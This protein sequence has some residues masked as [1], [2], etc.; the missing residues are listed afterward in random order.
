MQIKTLRKHNVNCAEC[1]EG[2]NR[3]DLYALADKKKMH[4]YCAKIRRLH[5]GVKWWIRKLL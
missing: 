1:G 3:L 2:I 4:P 5:S